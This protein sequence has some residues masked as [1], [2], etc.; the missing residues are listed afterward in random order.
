MPNEQNINQQNFDDEINIDWSKIVKTLWNGKKFILIFTSAITILSI[1][2]SLSLP[3]YYKSS[4]VLLPESSNKGASG[5]SGLAAL[6]G[7]NVGGGESSIALYPTIIKSETILK[8]IIY[9]KYQTEEFSNPVN[10][11]EY[12]EIEDTNRAKQYEIA[13]KTLKTEL[14]ISWDNKLGGITTISISTKEAN[15]SAEIVNQIV[16]ELDDFLRTKKTTNAGNQREFIETRLEEVKRDLT[17]SENRLKEFRE[18]NRQVFAPQLLLEQE[19]LL[20][21]ITIN[22]TLYSELRKQYEL[23]KIEEIKNIPVLNVMD[24]ARPNAMKDKPKRSTI[25]LGTFIISLLGAVGFVFA[26]NIFGDKFKDFKKS[27]S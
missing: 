7:I 2:Y 6:A 3:N 8:N 14:E 12:W 26:K 4:T 22:G 16:L 1:I 13:L 17:S 10:L 11:I 19:R 24:P 18:R 27:L 25:V 15:L 5:L 9:K 20:R 23:A 21:D